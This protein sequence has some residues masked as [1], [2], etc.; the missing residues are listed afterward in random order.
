MLKFISSQFLF[1]RKMSV[2]KFRDQT[3]IIYIF[4]NILFFV[5]HLVLYVVCS[6]FLFQKV[7]YSSKLF[8]ND[9]LNVIYKSSQWLLLLNI[10]T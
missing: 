8:I 2:E 9:Q 4:I 3:T 7:R 10:F 6:C 1:S 5:Q